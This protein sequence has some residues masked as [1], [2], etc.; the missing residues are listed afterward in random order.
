MAPKIASAAAMRS[1]FGG[2][3]SRTSKYATNT[4]HSSAVET[5]RASPVHGVPHVAS[6]QS[7]R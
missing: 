2:P 5:W 7:A 3:Y 6:P 1:E 4:S